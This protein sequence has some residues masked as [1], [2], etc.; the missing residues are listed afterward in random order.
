MGKTILKTALLTLSCI[1]VL[2]SLVLG[3]YVLLAPKALAEGAENLGLYSFSIN[4]YEQNYKKNKNIESLYLLVDKAILFDA[5]E[6]IIDYYPT[7]QSHSKYNQYIEALDIVNYDANRSVLTN[8][9]MSNCDNRLKSRYV[10]AL[11]SKDFETAFLYAK[12]DLL[13]IDTDSAKI[14][15]IYT[16]LATYIDNSNASMFVNDYDG[17]VVSTKIKEVYEAIYSRYQLEKTTNTKY[18]NAVISNKLVDIMQFMIHIN[19][20]ITCGYN[21]S[22]LQNQLQIVHGEYLSYIA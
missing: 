12:S 17:V 22:T 10:K 5:K 2:L 6:K 16:G 20:K 8:L 7:L 18:Q 15:F 3:G 13:A 21:E 19:K 1:V 4:M 11:A 14:N 9:A